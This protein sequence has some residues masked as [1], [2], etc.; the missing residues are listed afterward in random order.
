MLPP[1][2]TSNYLAT[3]SHTVQL[4]AVAD[5]YAAQK[6]ITQCFLSLASQ[7]DATT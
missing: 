1:L 5:F 2:S 6:V 3:T 7:K 4:Q